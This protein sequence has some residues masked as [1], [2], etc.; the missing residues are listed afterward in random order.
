MIVLRK[1]LGGALG[2]EVDC[3]YPPVRNDIVTPRHLFFFH[4]HGIS[5]EN[6]SEI[7]LGT[8]NSCCTWSE[9]QRH[10][11]SPLRVSETY[12]LFMFVFSNAVMLYAYISIYK[13]AR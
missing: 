11:S 9:L 12:S 8:W 4:S 7:S 13:T 1:R 2:V 6:A 10:L 5:A 3:P